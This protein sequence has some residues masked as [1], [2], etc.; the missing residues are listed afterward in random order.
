MPN[1]A[2]QPKL[3]RSVPPLAARGA[4]L[5]NWQVSILAVSILA[6]KGAGA[7]FRR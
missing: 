5:R 3:K 7:R 1:F 4:G 6:D 2:S